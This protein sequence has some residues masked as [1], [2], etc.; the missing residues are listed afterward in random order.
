MDPWWE[1]M[2]WEEAEA[3]AEAEAEGSCGDG[4]GR[5]WEGL[6]FEIGRAH[7]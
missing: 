1:M 7:V 3:E 5:A 2:W 6:G 4:R